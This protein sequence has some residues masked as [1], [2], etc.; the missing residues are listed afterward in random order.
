MESGVSALNNYIFY[1]VISTCHCM[2][3]QNA[4]SSLAL[5]RDAEKPVGKIFSQPGNKL[6]MHIVEF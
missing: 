1:I 5:K 4:P 2:N 6:E 3:W